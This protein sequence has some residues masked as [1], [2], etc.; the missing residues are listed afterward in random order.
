MQP[1][2]ATVMHIAGACDGSPQRTQG[3]PRSA[4][5]EIC[6]LEEEELVPPLAYWIA[7][8]VI[9]SIQDSSGCPCYS[10]IEVQAERPN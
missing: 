7:R 8:G 9:K 2:A 5:A 10:V 3:M 4:L 1:F 6:E